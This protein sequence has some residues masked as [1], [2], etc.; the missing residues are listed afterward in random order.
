[1]AYLDRVVLYRF[2]EVI[3]AK[4][5]NAFD[6]MSDQNCSEQFPAR[7]EP[8]FV[9]SQTPVLYID[10]PKRWNNGRWDKAHRGDS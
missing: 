7:S 1:M 2:H 9:E 5:R 3:L 6:Q 8:A 4:M 10:W